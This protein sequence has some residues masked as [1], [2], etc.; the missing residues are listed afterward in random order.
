MDILQ[1]PSKILEIADPMI[2]KSSLPNFLASEL[3]AECVRVSTPD[4]L[5]SALQRHI[6]CWRQQQ[7]HML[8]HQHKSV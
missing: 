8:G 1:M 3:K 5:D 6:I 2:G 4:E 7:M